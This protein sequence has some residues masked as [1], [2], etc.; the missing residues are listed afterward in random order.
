MKFEDFRKAFSS[1]EVYTPPS[2]FRFTH[3]YRDMTATVE[4]AA[5]EETKA[6]G[7]ASHSPANKLK[8]T[9]ST[10]ADDTNILFI[11]NSNDTS[12]DSG[13]V[14]LHFV[15]S[16]LSNWRED[17]KDLRTERK[18]STALQKRRESILSNPLSQR[19]SFNYSLVRSGA[20]T[21]AYAWAGGRAPPLTIPEA[22]EEDSSSGSAVYLPPTPPSPEDEEE[23]EEEEGE[24][25][26]GER[27]VGGVLVVEEFN[28][29]SISTSMPLLRLVTSGVKGAIVKVHRSKKMMKFHVKAPVGYHLSISSNDDFVLYNE[30]AAYDSMHKEG[31]GYSKI[32][33]GPVPPLPPN[34]WA[35]VFREVLQVQRDQQLLAFSLDCPVPG[36]Q[37]R[38]VDNDDG[39]EMPRVAHITEP[40]EYNINKKGYTILCEMWTRS[41]PVVEGNIWKLRVISSDKDLPL[42]EGLEKEDEGEEDELEQKKNEEDEEKN[43][44]EGAEGGG[45]KD[46]ENVAEVAIGTEFHHKEVREYCL[47]DRDS[48]LFRYSL[49]AKTECPITVQLTTSKKDAFIKLEIFQGSEFDGSLVAVTQGRAYCF[50]PSFFM[51]PSPSRDADTLTNKFVMVATVLHKSWPFAD[52]AWP[53]IDEIRSAEEEKAN[54]S[55]SAGGGGG[56]GKKPPSASSKSGSG[57]KPKKGKGGG[58]DG[59]GKDGSDGVNSCQSLSNIDGSKPHWTL[60]VAIR[61]RDKDQFEM[62]RDTEREDELKS[63]QTTWETQQPGRLKQGQES[64]QKF[65]D[66]HSLK[67]PDTNSEDQQHLT[68]PSTPSLSSSTTP[69]P[70]SPSLL[71]PHA[72]IPLERIDLSLYTRNSNTTPHVLTAEERERRDE[73]RKESICQYRAWRRSVLE[74]R[75]Q[76]RQFRNSEKLRQLQEA[77]K[78]QVCVYTTI[79]DSSLFM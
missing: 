63:M 8:G 46:G 26:E 65:L 6:K 27:V 64:R 1:V 56:K 54:A 69:L 20:K 22:D 15:F 78:Q 12:G 49:R 23:E 29:R 62:G 5:Q 53:Y 67:P 72:P 35:V 24:K 18:K 36:H 41:D 74:S 9:E 58:K 71:P 42:C 7:R 51:S 30:S 4:M 77:E 28:W 52:T 68:V 13:E 32:Y 34:S 21:S 75:D 14:E 76:D 3:C 25:E 47:P 48:V 61:Q 10:V 31:V 19:Y 16:C 66:A 17:S 79:T 70:I 73:E 39:R 2:R 43:K 45:E 55:G 37:L 33:S 60:R 44:E 40:Q 38:V 57:A 11:E 59:G 50:I